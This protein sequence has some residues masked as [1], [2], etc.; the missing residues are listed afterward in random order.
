MGLHVVAKITSRKLGAAL[1]S[2]FGQQLPSDHRKSNLSFIGN[3]PYIHYTDQL[4]AHYGA[5]SLQWNV[6]YGFFGLFVHSMRFE[7]THLPSQRNHNVAGWTLP[8]W[9][10]GPHSENCKK[11]PSVIL[12]TAGFELEISEPF[13]S[14]VGKFRYMYVVT[15]TLYRVVEKMPTILVQRYYA[16]CHGWFS[17]KHSKRIFR[18]LRRKK[19]VLLMCKCNRITA[20]I[21]YRK[22]WFIFNN[23]PNKTMFLLSTV[24]RSV[25]FELVLQLIFAFITDFYLCLILAKGRIWL[26]RQNTHF[27]TLNALVLPLSHHGN[28]TETWPDLW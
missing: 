13:P 2:C 7:S 10:K 26:T 18:S 17:N 14:F 22:L 4:M 28:S 16:P 27:L 19:K 24:A 12:W 20:S 15:T 23:P 11:A 6:Q 1:S 5:I 8:V 9:S 25:N 3:I 21:I